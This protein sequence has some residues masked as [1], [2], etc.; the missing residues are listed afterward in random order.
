M[1][2]PAST[3]QEQI[4]AALAQMLNQ[5][6]AP[7]AGGWGAAAAAAP[8]QVQA[9]NVPLKLQLPDGGTLRVYVQLPGELMQSQQAL[10]GAIQGMMQQ[11]FPLDVWRPQGSGD[12]GN[13][14]GSWG[15]NGGNRGGW[16]SRGRGRW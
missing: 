15:S 5:Q 14:G 2:T 10:M 12:W 13:S 8:L 11:G 7:A 9:V 16:G 3:M 4:Q 6:H 1:S